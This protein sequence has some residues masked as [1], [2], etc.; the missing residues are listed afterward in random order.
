MKTLG[1]CECEIKNI[2]CYCEVLWL[3][4]LELGPSRGFLKKRLSVQGRSP[5]MSA[6][7]PQPL[8]PPLPWDLHPQAARRTRAMFPQVRPGTFLPADNPGLKQR[9]QFM[10]QPKGVDLRTKQL[11]TLRP[12]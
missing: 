5:A 8:L 3:C 7:L 11:V 6:L 10:E 1:R 9:A 4:S 2:D 12:Q